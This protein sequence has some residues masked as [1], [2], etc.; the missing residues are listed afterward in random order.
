MWS[1]ALTGDYLYVLGIFFFKN[2]LFI[3]ENR[4]KRAKCRA[5]ADRPVV[6]TLLSLLGPVFNPWSRN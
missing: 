1:V 2:K 5:F 3:G 6:R 4:L